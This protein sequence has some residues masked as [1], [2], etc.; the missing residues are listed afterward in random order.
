[1]NE[2]SN[3]IFGRHRN[4][5]FG[6]AVVILILNIALFVLVPQQTPVEINET[7]TEYAADDENFAVEHT[8]QLTGT[9]TKS[10]IAKNTFEGTIWMSDV[11]GLDA[12]LGVH[13]TREDGRWH[14]YFTDESGQPQGASSDLAEINAGK[15]FDDIVITFWDAREQKEDGGISAS[16]DA[17]AA[18]FA[19]V[20]AANRR[21]ALTLFRSYYPVSIDK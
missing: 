11:D 21:V 9:L 10:M 4:L 16:Y 12:P 8:V 13:L 6:F 17:G 20:G 7:V 18:H 15:D 1:M 19:A 3:N 2:E 5:I 14:G